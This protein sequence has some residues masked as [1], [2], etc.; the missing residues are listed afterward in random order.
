MSILDPGF[1]GVVH[2]VALP[3]QSELISK[4]QE[5]LVRAESL[6]DKL[7]KVSS[8]NF[9]GTSQPS[10]RRICPYG[11]VSSR[12]PGKVSLLESTQFIADSEV[13]VVYEL[14]RSDLSLQFLG[15]I[16][17]AQKS[18]GKTINR[19]KNLECAN[20]NDRNV[21]MSLQDDLESIKLTEQRIESVATTKNNKHVILQQALRSCV[22]TCV[23]ML[24][25]DAGKTPEFKA[26]ERVDLA[27]ASQAEFWIKSSG[28]EPKVTKLQNDVIPV[29][30][31]CLKQDG[32]G[33]IFV[34]DSVLGG[35]AIILDCIDLENN[36]ATIRDPFH[37]WMIDIS[38][39]TLVKLSP[40]V[41][42]HVITD[43]LPLP[44]KSDCFL[45][46]PFNREVQ[47]L[48]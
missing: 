33:I 5:V 39:E 18:V 3:T 24:L 46:G 4:K 43:I 28:C 30:S 44:S 11:L 21:R 36:T 41:I 8:D 37:G 26:I 15:S 2:S 29:L 20:G 38:L 10:F 31:Q 22:P 45:E 27:T 42:I 9:Y 1:Y 6:S 34:E 7:L 12:A 47:H 16:Q 17:K 48:T 13:L 25:L 35:H 32:P 23:G 40:N 14:K 19:C